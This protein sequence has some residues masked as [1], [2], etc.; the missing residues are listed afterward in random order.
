MTWVDTGLRWVKPSPNI[1]YASSPFYYVVTGM[2]GELAGLE[3][4]V[5]SSSPFEIAASKYSDANRI[6]NAMRSLHAPGVTFSP[7]SQGFNCVRIRIEPHNDSNLTALGIHLLALLNAS[8]RPDLFARSQG[9]KRD[10]FFKSY[11]SASIRDAIENGTAVP[12]IVA[13]WNPSISRFQSMRGQFLM[14]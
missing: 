3:T 12:R 9:E 11:G 14:Y 13:S 6:T 4:G 1:P 2:I 8:A 10:L 7:Y 5:G